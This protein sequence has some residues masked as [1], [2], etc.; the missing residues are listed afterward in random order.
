MVLGS[1]FGVGPTVVGL[2]VV[3]TP[4][5]NLAVGLDVDKVAS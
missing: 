5:D 2:E 4:V 3:V 1:P